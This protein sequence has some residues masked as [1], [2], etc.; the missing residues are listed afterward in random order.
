[1]KNK[2]HYPV[3][4]PPRVDFDMRPFSPAWMKTAAA[5]S[6]KTEGDSE[7]RPKQ[8]EPL[9]GSDAEE[10]AE[11]DESL[12]GGDTEE[13]DSTDSDADVPDQD[14]SDSDPSD[15][16]AEEWDINGFKPSDC[17]AED[18]YPEEFLLYY[19]YWTQGQAAFEVCMIDMP[20]C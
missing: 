10:R 4:Y 13:L 1:M 12:D 14:L 3:F 17:P 20:C 18:A 7:N 6:R 5:I 16:D 9:H 15:E 11:I 8:D 19:D 2:T